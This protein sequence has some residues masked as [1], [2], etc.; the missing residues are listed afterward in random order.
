MGSRKTMLLILYALCMNKM[1]NF[2]SPSPPPQFVSSQSQM[3]HTHTYTHTNKQSAYFLLNNVKHLHKG[4][5]M[6]LWLKIESV[7]KQPITAPLSPT[8]AWLIHQTTSILLPRLLVNENTHAHTPTHTSHSKQ[9][10][11]CTQSRTHACTDTSAYTPTHTQTQCTQILTGLL[12]STQRL[13]PPSW[14]IHQTALASWIPE[15]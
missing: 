14:L 6:S 13:P 8:Y 12:M 9:T 2:I 4:T 1:K 15:A 11:S 5:Q 7:P 10:N 3:P